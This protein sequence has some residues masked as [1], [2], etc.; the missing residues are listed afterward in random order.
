MAVTPISAVVD[1]SILVRWWR[2]S[3]YVVVAT[4][5]MWVLAFVMDERRA[6]GN[7]AL[8]LLGVLTLTALVVMAL[9]RSTTADQSSAP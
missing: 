7:S 6:P 3:G 9:L 2:R 5:G 1:R 8:T 4:I